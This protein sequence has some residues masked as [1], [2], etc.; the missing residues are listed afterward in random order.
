MKNIAIFASGSGTNA[1]AII[2]YFETTKTARVGIV[3]SNRRGAFVLERAAK[4]NIPT[5]CFNREMLYN[6]TQTILDTLR[7]YDVD[8]I[9]LAGFMMLVPVDI[10]R[11]YENRILNI[12]PALLPKYG[13]RGMYGDFVHEAVVAA[14]ERESGITIHYVND[15]YDKG[16]VI[17]QARCAVESTDTAQD[18]AAK[19]HRLEHAHFPRVIEQI[20]LSEI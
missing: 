6:E 8:L 12:H 3:L 7:S 15:H 10:I 9:I 18:V 2:D 4:H 5:L 17:F 16:D 19:V 13:G 20:I 11:A 14:G 1:Q